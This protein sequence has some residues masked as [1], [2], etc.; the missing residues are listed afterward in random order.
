MVS[1]HFQS[2]W[3]IVS[4]EASV[5]YQNRAF[6]A[7]DQDD[8]EVVPYRFTFN[9][10][11]SSG[12]S[13]FSLS[14]EQNFNFLDRSGLGYYEA[15]RFSLRFD[16]DLTGKITLGLNGYY[17]NSDY[18]DYDRDDDT[19]NILAD[20]NYQIKDRIALYFSAGYENRDSTIPDAEFKNTEILG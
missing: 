18:V 19:Y 13:R 7:P 10:R 4:L 11:S 3:S 16:Y 14:A 1:R 17:Q 5:G 2:C 9:G 8:I 15:N 20:I 12:K 6:D